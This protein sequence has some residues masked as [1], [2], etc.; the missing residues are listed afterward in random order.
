MS[1][2]KAVLAGLSKNNNSLFTKAPNILAKRNLSFNPRNTFNSI[3]SGFWGLTNKIPFGHAGKVY[4]GIVGAA[5]FYGGVRGFARWIDWI[6]DREPIRINY[7]LLDPPVNISRDAGYFAWYV[8]TGAAASAIVAGTAPVSVP[9]ILTFAKKKD[10][11]TTDK[12]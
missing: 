4:A 5:S 12:L 10:K 8:G 9:L 3:Y 7:E 1:F 6:T 11:I 2:S